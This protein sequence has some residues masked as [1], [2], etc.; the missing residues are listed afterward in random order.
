MTAAPW[1]N[2]W[3]N[4]HYSNMEDMAVEGMNSGVAQ[5][6]YPLL[7]QLVEGIYVGYKSM[8]RPPPRA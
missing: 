3:Q 2:N 7:R 6:Y 1:W 4:T 5:T 8:R